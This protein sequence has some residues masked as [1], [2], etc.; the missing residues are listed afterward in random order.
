MVSETGGARVKTIGDALMAAFSDP[1][2]AVRA[3][4]EMQRR[5]QVWAQTLSLD[6]PP[7]LKVGI[8]WGPAMAV[9]TDQAG[10]DWFGGTVNLAARC[11]G[12][13]RAGEV[14]WTADVHDRPGLL[15]MLAHEAVSFE[16]YD[17]QVKGI[18]KAVGMVRVTV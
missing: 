1:L 16:C 9:H 18:T 6:T 11:E 13:A 14:I 17:A 5:F 12:Q 3:G 7:G 2:D 15:D 10:L 8:H 4:L